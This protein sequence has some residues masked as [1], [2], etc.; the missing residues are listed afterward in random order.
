M[1][2]KTIYNSEADDTSIAD[3]QYTIILQYIQDTIL[4]QRQKYTNT[5]H[6]VQK[7]VCSTIYLY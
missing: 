6:A 2:N 4:R 5:L 7:E 1:E 3:E